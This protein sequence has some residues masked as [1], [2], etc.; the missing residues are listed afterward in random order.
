MVFQLLH[1]AESRVPRAQSRASW[2]PL[3]VFH[4]EDPVC[5]L[6]FLSMTS[7]IWHLAW[8]AVFIYSF[9]CLFVGQRR[10]W[11]EAVAI[12]LSDSWLTKSIRIN[13]EQ[14]H[15]SQSSTVEAMGA[16]WFAGWSNHLCSDGFSI[17][18]PSREPSA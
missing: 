2:G 11:V 10:G 15:Q 3:N 13:I 16:E 4:L 5:S 14:T 8:F 6:I 9:N 12:R 1:R 7:L 17:T 18:P